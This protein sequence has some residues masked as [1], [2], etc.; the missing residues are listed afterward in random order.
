MN[1]NVSAQISYDRL[2]KG[3]DIRNPST[4]NFLVDSN[5]R[6]DD[7]F[8]SSSNFTITKANSLFN[9]FFTRFALTEVVLTWMV[10]N[11]SARA[12]NN[13]MVVNGALPS[14]TITLP[15]GSYTVQQCLTQLV[16]ELNKPA[17]AGFGAGY[18]ALRDSTLV[19]GVQEL[20]TTNA[21]NFWISSSISVENGTT[22]VGLAQSLSLPTFTSSPGVGFT[23]NKYSIVSPNIVPYDYIDFTSPQLTSQQ[24]VKDSS[25]AQYSPDVI[26]RWVF[27][28]DEPVGYDGYG[29]PILQSYKSFKLRRYLSF[30]KQLRWD[31]LIPLGQIQFQILDNTGTELD[32][33]YYRYG[34]S[35]VRPV[36]APERVEFNML[37][38]VSEV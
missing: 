12:A 22:V 9:G 5:D 10:P 23:T 14:V 31:P 38:L 33:N 30:P 26:Y 21:T 36:L 1:R 2:N 8:P 20:Y 18:F 11:I 35:T 27:A 3:V 34:S 7:S 28:D 6:D 37:F 32:Y 15:D 4:A 16:F 29:Y 13:T 19:P 17:P 24:D 25:T